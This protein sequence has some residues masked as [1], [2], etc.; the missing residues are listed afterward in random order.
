MALRARYLRRL[1]LPLPASC[2][3]DGK[4]KSEPTRTRTAVPLLRQ[5]SR[6]SER[7]SRTLRAV[8]GIG[9][10]QNGGGRAQ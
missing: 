6:S 7:P 2:R 4:R 9:E 5:A 8:A 1:P 10:R 3:G